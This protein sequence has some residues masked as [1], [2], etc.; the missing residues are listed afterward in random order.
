MGQE[1][2][3]STEPIGELLVLRR[4]AMAPNVSFRPRSLIARKSYDCALSKAVADH[5]HVAPRKWLSLLPPIS[6]VFPSAES[7]A[8]QH[9]SGC[10]RPRSAKKSCGHTPPNAKLADAIRPLF[11]GAPHHPARILGRED[12]GVQ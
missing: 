2:A 5:T 8:H 4:P 10:T 11:C 1:E 12:F 7:G 9:D 6:A 3:V